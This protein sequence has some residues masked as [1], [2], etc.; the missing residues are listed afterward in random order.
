MNNFKLL[1]Q[2][3][4]IHTSSPN[5]SVLLVKVEPGLT[6]NLCSVD[7]SFVHRAQKQS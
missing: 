2:R 6:F 5:S 1:A 3:H 4:I 7:M